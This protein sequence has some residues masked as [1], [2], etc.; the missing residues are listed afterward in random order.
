MY[1]HGQG[2]KQSNP[3]ALQWYRLAAQQGHP[4]AK[5]ALAQSFQ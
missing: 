2:V 4:Q 1:F 3:D 5:N